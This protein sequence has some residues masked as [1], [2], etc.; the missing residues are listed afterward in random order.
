MEIFSQAS[1]IIISSSY[2]SRLAAKRTV[3]ADK[4]DSEDDT[5]GE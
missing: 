4:H 2:F 1:K 3:E 5:P